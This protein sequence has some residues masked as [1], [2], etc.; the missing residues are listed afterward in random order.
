M[1]RH[2]QY[3]CIARVKQDGADDIM[4]ALVKVAQ[5]PRLGHC[6]GS[7][8]NKDGTVQGEIIGSVQ[9]HSTTR[10]VGKCVCVV[11][12]GVGA[13]KHGKPR[14]RDCRTTMV[15]WLWFR[16]VR[17]LDT[18]TH[19]QVAQASTHADLTALSLHG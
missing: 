12:K 19:T 1:K 11:A 17:G 2:S 13:H 8:A 6:M 10:A 14:C 3:A 15:L 18:H 9:V 7:E 16:A 5:P 4:V